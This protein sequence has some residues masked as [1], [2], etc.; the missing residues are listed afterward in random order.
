V[1][2]RSLSDARQL[3]WFATREGKDLPGE[4]VDAIVE[5][6]S[7]LRSGNRD[8]GIEG[9]FWVAFRNLAAGVRP[10]SVDSIVATYGVGDRLVVAAE[11]TK[12]RYSIFAVLVLIMLVVT[13]IYW[14]VGTTL[15]TDLEMHRLEQDKISGSLGELNS[16][17]DKI[18][19]QIDARQ[20]EQRRII[21]GLDL[22]GGS[23]KAEDALATVKQLGQNI[24]DLFQQGAKAAVELANIQRRSVRILLMAASNG[25]FLD[26]WD[27]ITEIVAPESSSTTQNIGWLQDVVLDAQISNGTGEPPPVEPALVGEKG[28]P[29]APAAPQGAAP[30]AGATPVVDGKTPA[31]DGPAALAG[32]VTK[33]QASERRSTGQQL[34][35]EMALL[36]SK[37]VVAVL[38]Q[39][40]LPLLYG[41]LGALAYV[42]RTLSIEIHEVTFTRSSSIRYSLRWPLGMLGGVTVGLFF[43][44]A[45]FTGI[46]A[47]TPWGLAFLAGYGVELFFTAL[48]KMI[49]A[50]TGDTARSA[51]PA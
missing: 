29:V 32:W 36:S 6:E 35:F 4:I 15:R 49:Q 27:F 2:V 42:L 10:V 38:S 41:L 20:D 48:D 22:T 26:R 31:V 16:E 21:S 12:R 5:A 8:P 25:A 45:S 7:V 40:L 51:R 11:R 50:F 46:A 37:S 19:G 30:P 44:P 39:Y 9:R 23:G 34:R 14:F 28:T 17:L 33:V 43:D 3:L 24:D 13:Q 47:I 18:R 1:L